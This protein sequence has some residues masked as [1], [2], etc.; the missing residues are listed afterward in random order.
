MFEQFSLSSDIATLVNAVVTDDSKIEIVPES[1]EFVGAENQTSFYDGSL[2]ELKIDA[3]ILLTSGD[4]NPPTENTFGSY[5]EFGLGNTDEQLQAVADSAF[6]GNG[7]VTDANTLEFSFNITDPNVNSV[8]FDIVFGSDEFPEFSNSDFVDV[9]AVFVNDKNVALFN[10]E[11][12]QPL[13]IID[14]NLNA[15]NF[16]DNTDNSLPIEYDGISSV[17]TVSAPVNQGE[18]TIKF[19]VADTGDQVLDSG[20]FIANLSTSETDIGDSGSGVLIDTPG[21]NDN[22][23]IIG[24]DNDD[25]F[26]VFDGDDIV[27]AGKGSDLIEA[28]S[29]DDKVRAGDGNDI[30]NGDMGDD[31]LN[32]GQHFDRIFGGDGNDVLIGNDGTDIL[33]GGDGKD[34]FYLQGNVVKTDWIQ[35]FDPNADC[36]GLADGLSQDNIDITGE[37]NSFI[38]YNGDL[39]AVLLNVNP[40]ELTDKNFQEF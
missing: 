19:G 2:E 10:N 34:L 11:A 24:T 25:F 27:N 13:S 35:D 22:D 40:N 28:G 6:E 7:G 16:I 8:F 30:L 29:G 9:G 1:I 3:G 23:E 12:T 39:I 18:N 15:G 31:I 5:G 26:E 36:I 37:V 33:N 4:G 20:L 17:L 38:N 32:G 14:E 21:S